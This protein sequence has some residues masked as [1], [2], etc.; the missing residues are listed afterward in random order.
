MGLSPDS[1]QVLVRSPDHRLRLWSMGTG[2][3][4]APLNGSGFEQ[5]AIGI[6]QDCVAA[7]DD[8][9]Q[10]FLW[11]LRTG[12]P[13][14]VL[15]G[16]GSGSLGSGINAIALS[17]GQLL[18]ATNRAGHLLIV[19]WVKRTLLAKIAPASGVTSLAFF[20]DGRALISG[21][22]DGSV[23]IWQGDDH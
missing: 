8:S 6:G 9:G 18:A 15:D 3:P 12:Q 22:A 5:T 17:P 4:L 21:H 20:A 19:D 14:M 16:L 11:R 10:I 2:V 7:G 13:I 1:K 23:Q